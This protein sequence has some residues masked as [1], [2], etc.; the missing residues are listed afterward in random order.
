[1]QSYH[2]PEPEHLQS[3]PVCAYSEQEKAWGARLQ[4][5]PARYSRRFL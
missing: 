3:G 2:S 4:Q 5:R 1:M